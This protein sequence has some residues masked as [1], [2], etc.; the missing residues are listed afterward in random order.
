[1]PEPRC[2]L[3]KRKD[4]NTLVKDD[5]YHGVPKSKRRK[6][7]T[8]EF[9]DI[10]GMVSQIVTSEKRTKERSLEDIVEKVHRWRD[11]YSGVLQ[12]DK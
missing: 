4:H 6:L 5:N 10:E 3:R 7:N 1:M 8:N 12:V 9:M 2:N 11:L